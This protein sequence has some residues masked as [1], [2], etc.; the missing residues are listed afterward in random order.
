MIFLLLIVDCCF[1]R[2]LGKAFAIIYL[3]PPHFE[4]VYELIKITLLSQN[5]FLSE[6][7]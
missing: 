2:Y 4:L 7:I 6:V 1:L 5:S 3:S